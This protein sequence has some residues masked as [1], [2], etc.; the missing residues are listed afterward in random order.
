MRFANA[1]TD[2]LSSCVTTKKT[3]ARKFVENAN[4]SVVFAGDV[5]I[6]KLTEE[7][8]QRR[9]VVGHRY[10]ISVRVDL[11]GKNEVDVDDWLLQSAMTVIAHVMIE[12]FDDTL[13]IGFDTG[14]IGEPHEPVMTKNGKRLFLF[15][16]SRWRR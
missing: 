8:D 15:V 10:R 16:V 11:E 7:T 4:E 3:E 14:V 6:K 2:A 1:F 5:A 12:K 9:Y 13:S